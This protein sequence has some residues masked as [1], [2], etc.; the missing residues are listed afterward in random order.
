MVR[1][2]APTGVRFHCAQG[3]DTRTLAR[4][5]NSL[6]R[7]TRRVAGRHYASIRAYAR[8]LDPRRGVSRGL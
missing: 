8:C 3:L 4:Q 5:V 2:K 7:V 1:P 6:V